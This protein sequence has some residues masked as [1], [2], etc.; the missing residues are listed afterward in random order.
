M[1]EFKEIN[2]Q[3]IYHLM[4]TYYSPMHHDDLHMVQIKIL[5][6]HQIYEYNKI[7]SSLWLT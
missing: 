6:Y 5:C 2:Y 3:T 1:D 4:F 7:C